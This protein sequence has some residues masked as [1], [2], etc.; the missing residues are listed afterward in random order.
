MIFRC[1]GYLLA[2]YLRFVWSHSSVKFI[3]KEFHESTR[4]SAPCIV[5]TWHGQHFM[6]PFVRDVDRD[7][8]V[9][10]AHGTFGSIYTNAFE[11]LGLKII[12]GSR[13]TNFHRKGGYRGFRNLLLALRSGT[14]IALTVDIPGSARVAGPGVIALARHSG[15]PIIPIAAVTKTRVSLKWRWDR[16]TINLPFSRLVVASG[17][18]IFVANKRGA[19]YLEHKRQELETALNRVNLEAAM[20]ADSCQEE[21]RRGL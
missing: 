6:V 18:P 3:P 20:Y 10:I 1:L 5:A 2:C 7:Y 19:E 14:S 13:G 15:R 4:N 21:A 8:F 11:R 9:L 17:A 12:R 16:P